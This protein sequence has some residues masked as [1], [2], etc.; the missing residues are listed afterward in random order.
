MTDRKSSNFQILYSISIKRFRVD[1]RYGFVRMSHSRFVVNHS[2]GQ[3][4]VRYG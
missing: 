4:G 1:T 3:S 2:V